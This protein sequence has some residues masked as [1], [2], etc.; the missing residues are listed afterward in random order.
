[1]SIKEL[2]DDDTYEKL[3]VNDTIGVDKSAFSSQDY[4]TLYLRKKLR[5]EVVD[6]FQRTIFGDT[7]IPRLVFPAI[8]ADKWKRFD[9]FDGLRGVDLFV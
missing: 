9:N 4:T 3:R 6:E 2:N 1:M 5:P 7:C 8:T